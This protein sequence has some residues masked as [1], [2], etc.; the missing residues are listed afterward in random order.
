MLLLP[1]I[2]VGLAAT[3]VGVV[4]LRLELRARKN[5]RLI[6]EAEAQLDASFRAAVASSSAGRGKTSPNLGPL[7]EDLGIVGVGSVKSLL[8]VYDAADDHA[9]FLGALQARLPQTFTNDTSPLKWATQLLSYG[10]RDSSRFKG[11]ASNWVGQLAEDNAVAYLNSMPDL[12][13]QGVRAELFEARN[14]PGYDIRLVAEDGSVV[15]ELQCKS[16]KDAGGFLSRLRD[17]QGQD[18]AVDHYIVNTEVYDQLE[19]SGKLTG[20]TE[21]GIV[22]ERGTWSHEDYVEQVGDISDAFGE[23]ADVSDNVG[24]VGALRWLGTGVRTA[25][26]VKRLAEG[27]TSVHEV[28]IDS[29]ADGAG[30]VGRGVSVAAGG[31]L[32]AVIGSAIFPG[33]GTLIGGIGGAIGGAVAG[34]YVPGIIK[35]FVDAWKFN[36]IREVLQQLGKRYHTDVLSWM[37]SYRRQVT[38]KI[39]KRKYSGMRLGKKVAAEESLVARHKIPDPYAPDM[40]FDVAGLVANR[41]LAEY[42]WVQRCALQASSSVLG[43][44]G[45]LVLGSGDS[46]VFGHLG[47]VVGANAAVLVC[48]GMQYRELLG[49]YAAETKKFPN[50]PFRVRKSYDSEPDD[51]QQFLDGICSEELR[52]AMQSGGDTL[53]PVSGWVTTG[54]VATLLLW[55][56]FAGIL[57]FGSS[58]SAKKLTPAA[59]ELAEATDTDR[60]S[61]NTPAASSSLAKNQVLGDAVGESAERTNASKVSPRAADPAEVPTTTV[62]ASVTGNGVRCR[63]GPSRSQS[64]VTSL[65]KGSVAVVIGQEGDWVELRTPDSETCWTHSSLAKVHSVTIPAR[66]R[67]STEST[68][69]VQVAASKLRC[70]SGPGLGHSVVSSM[71]GWTI[72]PLVSQDED[73]LEI[74]LDGTGPCFLSSKFARVIACEPGPAPP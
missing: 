45:K 37:G 1:L 63:S 12:Q 57:L 21:Q 73:W 20:L 17:Y 14:H 47:E 23:A 36:K 64:T 38:E 25:G 70:R 19:S 2:A 71:E 44:L 66:R 13:G 41:C 34:G 22:V 67:Q 15:D 56:I 10:E 46:A 48:D 6:F 65:K 53:Y 40:Q 72:A 28:A 18:Q 54:I 33:I 9:A 31:K 29:A 59:T 49:E 43:R 42:R 8:E 7:L 3:I 11:L 58:L 16:Y 68:K 39:Y 61:S 27:K 52:R 24:D 62:L 74:H 32:G 50:H 5:R 26:R 69:C 51:S 4:T 35:I 60:S 55:A 30:T